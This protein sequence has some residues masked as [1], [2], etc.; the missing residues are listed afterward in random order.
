MVTF[1]L[2]GAVRSFELRASDDM[3]L[4]W[5]LREVE[6]L[7]GTKYG[8]GVGACGA[9]T[10]LM[11]N[12]PVRSCQ[13]PRVE[14]QGRNVVTIEGLAQTE[15]EFVAFWAS[16][17][18]FQCGYCAPGMLIAMFAQFASARNLPDPDARIRISNICRC[19]SYP[20]V[21]G[22]LRKCRQARGNWSA[23]RE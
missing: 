3:P 15:R 8:C 5:H 22:G 7:T 9:C 2:N 19:G 23:A 21:L 4:L 18:V 20:A 1:S 6:K 17:D 12:V 10:V 13:I 11:D 16:E 14:V